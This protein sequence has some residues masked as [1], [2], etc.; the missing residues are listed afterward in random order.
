ML[1]HS[2]PYAADGSNLP[3][4]TS[5]PSALVTPQVSEQLGVK[6]VLGA[7]HVRHRQAKTI[8]NGL[9]QL[10]PSGLSLPNA[11]RKHGGANARVRTAPHRTALC[12]AC[13]VPY[14]CATRSLAGWLVGWARQR[15]QRT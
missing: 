10:A 11:L 9:K 6:W 12:T 13:G 3:S 5:D 2:V 7:A 15:N 4:S 14:G 8:L 1:C